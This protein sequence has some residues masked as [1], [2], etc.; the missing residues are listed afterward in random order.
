[1]E[2]GNGV[3]EFR[4]E[5]TNSMSE[6]EWELVHEEATRKV[7]NQIEIAKRIEN[8]ARKSERN[9]FI[10][11]GLFLTALSFILPMVVSGDIDPIATADKRLA[12][13]AFEFIE[14]PI[15]VSYGFTIVL[16]TLVYI[17]IS[18]SIAVSHLFIVSLYFNMI[19]SKVS[20]VHNTISSSSIH[21]L[22]HDTPESDKLKKCILTEYSDIIAVN[23]IVV[24]EKQTIKKL[25]DKYTK[26]GLWTLFLNVSLIYILV[27]TINPIMT[28]LSFAIVVCD[29]LYRISK[30]SGLLEQDRAPTLPGEIISIFTPH[31]Y[32]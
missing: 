14:T 10:I 29:S 8:K 1:M 12:I 16:L 6:D 19:A 23:N 3:K 25:G 17:P 28:F 7:E 30:I 27:I 31:R 2:P 26:I 4:Y 20:F 24:E 11:F 13:L 22:A 9:T 5:G 21:D 18:L 32:S 15:P